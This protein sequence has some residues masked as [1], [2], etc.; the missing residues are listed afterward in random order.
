LIDSSLASFACLALF[1]RGT[2]YHLRAHLG[3]II[4]CL[5]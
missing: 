5:L 2:R 1:G 3:Q 4:F